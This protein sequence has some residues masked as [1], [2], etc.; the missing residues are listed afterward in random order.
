MAS[1]QQ[2]LFQV[3]QLEDSEYL[4]QQLITYIGNKRLLIPFIETGLRLVRS[5]ISSDKITFL[6]L[7]S[8]SGVVARMARQY[9]SVVHC[10][11]LEVYSEIINKC[12]QTNAEDVDW[13]SLSAELHRLSLA[14]SMD[15]SPGF[16]TD[17]YSPQDESNIRP[18]ERVF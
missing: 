9:S 13:K 5:K 17:L 1:T 15:R 4:R 14:T 16:I 7:F 6:D 3:D 11:D 10:N 18:G 2:F 8:G 12:Y